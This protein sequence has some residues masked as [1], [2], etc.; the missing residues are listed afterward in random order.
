MDGITYSMDMSLSKL[1][2]IVKNREA[3]CVASHRI[4]ESDMTERLSSNN[5]DL[6]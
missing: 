6:T 4:S 2:V 5:V 3:W 1:P